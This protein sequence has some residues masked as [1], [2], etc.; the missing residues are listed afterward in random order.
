MSET[1]R[2]MALLNAVVP[3]STAE[4]VTEHLIAHGF[5][6]PA[7]ADPPHWERAAQM[8]A[9]RTHGSCREAHATLCALLRALRAAGYDVVQR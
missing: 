8:I 7:E 1:R 6:L 4:I 5:T 9:N 3:P 2:W